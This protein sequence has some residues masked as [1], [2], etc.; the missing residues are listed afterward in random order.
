MTTCQKFVS[1][2]S[3]LSF[4]NTFNPYRDCCPVFDYESS[5]KMRRAMFLSILSAACDSGVDALWIGRDLGYRG[6][7]RTGLALT[8]QVNVE[9]HLRRWG[10]SG[11]EKA[12]VKG[13]AQAERTASVVWEMVEKI[14]NTVFMWNVFPLHPHNA[15][16]HFSNRGH[17]S[18]ERVAGEEILSAM[19]RLLRPKRLIAIGQD[20]ANSAQRC[21]SNGKHDVVA[22]RHPSYG[23]LRDFQSGIHKAYGFPN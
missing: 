18:K 23:G 15:E 12:L 2:L 20:A 8:D 10:V 16:N 19:I 3:S 9:A 22:V 21:A 13:S 14:E 17:T 4:S 11:S 7:R 1:E 5:P 6:G